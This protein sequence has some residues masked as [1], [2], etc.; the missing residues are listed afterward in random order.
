MQSIRTVSAG[1]FIACA[2]VLVPATAQAQFTATPF[3]DPATGERYHIEAS[4]N[5]W[6]PPPVLVV[7]SEQFGIAGS[8]IDAVADL[9]IQQK[10]LKELRLVLR[11]AR[12]H[13][14][15]YNYLSAGY[16]SQTTIQREF[17]FNGIRYG[18][19]LPITSDLKWTTHM[20]G[21]EYDFLYKDNWFVGFVVQS[22]FTRV[23]INLATPVTSDFALAQAPVPTF[24]GI[25]RVYVTPNI[26]ITGELTGIKIPDTISTDYNAHYFDFDLYGTVNFNDYAGAQVGFRSIDVGYKFKK[27]EGT[28]E[29]KG[30]YFGGVVRY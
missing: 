14:F 27:D 19:N 8:Q 13:K 28:F 2:L 18:V 4:G 11:P 26:S 15:R 16:D 1:M 24:G 12:K 29:M 22:K 10:W 23:D 7:A 6:N 9:G 30:L 21:Y 5:L 17:V 25:G 20:L 3:S